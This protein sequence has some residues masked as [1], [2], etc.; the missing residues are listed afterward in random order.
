MPL[1]SLIWHRRDASKPVLSRD[2]GYSAEEQAARE[3]EN[4]IGLGDAP[5]HW[6]G[7]AVLGEPVCTLGFGYRPANSRR[8]GRIV[9]PPET[10]PEKPLSHP[11]LGSAQAIPRQIKPLFGG[12]YFCFGRLRHDC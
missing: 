2:F 11:F 6:G 1:L 8:V 10:A 3:R 5:G 4:S 7:G 9:A 12:R